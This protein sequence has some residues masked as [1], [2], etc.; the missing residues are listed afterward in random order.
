MAHFEVVVE[1]TSAAR[2]PTTPSSPTT[3]PHVGAT[4]DEVNMAD[5][6][7]QHVDDQ[8]TKVEDIAGTG[9]HDSLGG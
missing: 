9:E 8:G 6:V 5:T 1:R 7:P 4:E 3:D 2:L